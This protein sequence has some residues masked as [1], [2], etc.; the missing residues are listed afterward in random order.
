[1]AHSFLLCRVQTDALAGY[2]PPHVVPSLGF[3]Q[4]PCTLGKSTYLYALFQSLFT[5]EAGHP[6]RYKQKHSLHR[7]SL[8]IF[9][10]SKLSHSDMPAFTEMA[11]P[12]PN[13]PSWGKDKFM[14]ILAAPLGFRRTVMGDT[15]KSIQGISSLVKGPHMMSALM[16][17]CKRSA[18]LCPN[19]RAELLFSPLDGQVTSPSIP[20]SA[21][22][23]RV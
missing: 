22:F 6:A 16:A 1:M 19:S 9:V 23:S 17:D 12:S 3:H 10:S 2:F 11:F 13:A 14:I 21:S 20:K 5:M 4:F 18:N 15:L 8:V 7:L